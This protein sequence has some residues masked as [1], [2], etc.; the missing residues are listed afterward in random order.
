MP[1]SRCPLFGGSES[2]TGV[3]PPPGLRSRSLDL[4]DGTVPT[5]AVVFPKGGVGTKSARNF[6]RRQPSLRV[7][8]RGGLC[9]ALAFRFP[10]FISLGNG[11]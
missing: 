9:L 8:Q 7:S 11:V 1:V 5:G 6:G 3:A 4:A 2:S 10:A